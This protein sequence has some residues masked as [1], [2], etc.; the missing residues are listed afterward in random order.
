VSVKNRLQGR[1][2]RVTI[3]GF[4][5]LKSIENLGIPRLSVLIGE[6]GAGKANFIRFFEMI[7]WMNGRKQTSDEN[8]KLFDSRQLLFDIISFQV[9]VH[10]HPPEAVPFSSAP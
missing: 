6:N 4:R 2:T 1:I 9:P 3:H 5:T 7:R 10:R 8:V